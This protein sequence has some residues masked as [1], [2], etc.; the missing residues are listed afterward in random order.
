MRINKI[1]SLRCTVI[2][3]QN[4]KDIEVI[5]IIGDIEGIIGD[6]NKRYK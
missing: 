4:T 2:K 6:N 3:K 5:L 1:F